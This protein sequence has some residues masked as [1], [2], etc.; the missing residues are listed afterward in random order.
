MF[1][2]SWR[3]RASRYSA[4]QIAVRGTPSQLMSD[5][6][7]RRSRGL[8]ES[9][10][11][12]PPGLQGV[13]VLAE[14]RGVHRDHDVHP[15][16]PAEVPRL[17]HPHLVP[18]GQ[19]L[20][21]RGED[22]A[23]ADRHPHPEHRLREQVVRARRARAVDVGELDDEVVD[24]A[25]LRHARRPS[26]SRAGTSACPHALV[27]QRS[28]H[29]PQCRHTSSSLTITRSVLRRSET[30]IACSSLRAGAVSRR[31]RSA[32]SPFAVKV[33][34]SV[35]HTS[36]HASHSMHRLSVKTVCTSQLRQR[37]A[38]LKPRSLSKPSSTSMR[39]SARARSLS[40]WGT[41]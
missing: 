13:D 37:I 25:D 29:S 5:R 18:G 35:G 15:A 11:R 19:P 7:R 28:A 10:R 2:N 14:G 17:A 4:R 39:R 24:G 31:R 3:W 23:G 21:V 41:M 36:T 8:V 33:M 1:L 12:Y 30:R 40:A 20:D 27:G 32:S 26:S 22:V 16:A 38:S 9:W 6:Y 34:Q